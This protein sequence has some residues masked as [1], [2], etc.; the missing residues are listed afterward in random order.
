MASFVTPRVKTLKVPNDGE[1]EASDPD[2][3]EMMVAL[4]R[5]A[6][7]GEL[8]LR[9][10][11]PNVQPWLDYN[12]LSEPFDR[13]R[14]RQGVRQA[15][16]LAR[17]DGLKELLGDRL[18]PADSDLVSDE[19]LDAWMLREAVTY[20]HVSGTCKIGPSSDPTAVVDQYG[21]VYGLEVCG[22][23]MHP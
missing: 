4:L 16:Q 8:K 11:D 21:R 6:S 19:A 5:P 1:I 17:H 15:L 12:Y 3:A 22:W 9:S 23:R 18:E 14:L 7:R 10:T 2:L 13:Q 20:S